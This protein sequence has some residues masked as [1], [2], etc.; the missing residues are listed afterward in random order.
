[1]VFG[2]MIANLCV[3]DYLTRVPKKGKPKRKEV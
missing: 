1:M 3:D 2:G